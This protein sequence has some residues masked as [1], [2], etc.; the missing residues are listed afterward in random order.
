MSKKQVFSL[1]PMILQG[2][3]HGS[4][5]QQQA[6]PGRLKLD[7]DATVSK[8]GVGCCLVSWVRSCLVVSLLGRNQALQEQ[9]C[10]LYKPQGR[11]WISLVSMTRQCSPHQEL[12]L[13]L[14]LLRQEQMQVGLLGQS[15]LLP[16]ACCAMHN[17]LWACS[18][19]LMCSTELYHIA[20]LLQRRIMCS[21]FHCAT[22]S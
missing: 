10:Q 12:G 20:K 19:L 15:S 11:K 9:R 6:Q 22:T 3:R 13:A 16:F 4:T 14:K 8:A 21:L 1:P 18:T 17:L 5:A 2:Q 7:L